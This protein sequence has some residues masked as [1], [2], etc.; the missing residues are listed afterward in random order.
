MRG[1]GIIILGFVFCLLLQN[2]S[3]QDLSNLK[4]KKIAVQQEWLLIDSL[5]IVNGSVVIK[6]PQTDSIIP[7]SQYQIDF[8]NG[9]LKWLSPPNIDSVQITYRHFDFKWDKVYY[10]KKMPEKEKPQDFML[11]PFAY[12]PEEKSNRLI[13]FG[14]LDYNGTY[15]RG[16]SFG[17]NQDVVLNSNFNMQLSGYITEDI[18]VIAALTDNSI[19]VQPDGNT[20]Q[21]QEFDKVFIQIKKDPHILTVGDYEIKNPEGHFLRFFRNLQG[22]SY[23]SKTTVD[24]KGGEFWTRN[25]IAVARGQFNRMQLNVS[26]GNQGPYRL[27]GPNGET[28]III[29]AGTERVYIDGKLLERGAENDYV[30]DYNLGEISFT[31]NVLITRNKRVIVE[32]EYSDRNY[33]RSLISSN[34]SYEREKAKGF[35]NFYSLQDNKNQPVQ[36]D[37]TDEQK[38]F[39]EGIGNSQDGALFTGYRTIEE[40]DPDRIL[41]ELKD[42]TV[43][44]IIYDTVFAYS[45]NPE[46]AIYSVSYSYVGPGNGNYVPAISSANGRVFQWIAPVNGIPQGTYAPIIS[47]V[48][49]KRQQLL[50]GGVELT[51]TKN[52]IIRIEGAMSNNDGNTFSEKDDGGNI[53]VGAAIKYDRTTPLD[54]AK[55][56]NLYTTANYEFINRNFKPIE[57]YRDVEFTRDWNFQ[58]KLTTSDEHLAKAGIKLE[59]KD[60][61]NAAYYYSTYRVG[62]EYQG[63]ISEVDGLF[64]KKGYFLDFNM[65]HLSSD[66]EFEKSKFTRATLHAYKAFEKLKGWKIGGI[67]FPER[68]ITQDADSDSLLNKSF[69]FNEW[70]VYVE[71]ADSAT[72]R[73][74]FE[75]IRRQEFFPE[76]NE[77]NHTNTSNTYAI[78]GKWLSLKHHKLIW[79]LKYRQFYNTDSLQNTDKPE[80]YYLGRVEYNLNILRG[81]IT[82]NI[83]YELGSGQEQRVEY[84]YIEVPLGQGTYIWDEQTDYNDNG[85][86]ELNEFE[87]ATEANQTRAN[88]IRVATP[89]TE[90]DPVDITQYNQVL[91]INPR[92][93]LSNKKGILGFIARFNTITSLQVNRKVFRGADVSVFNPFVFNTQDESL[94]AISSAIRQSIFFNRTNTKY[95]LEYTFKDNK[96]KNNLVNGF[97]TRTISEHSGRIRWNVISSLNT[98]LNAKMGNRSNESELFSERNYD[99]EFY[100]IN[101]EVNFIYRNKFRIS[102][103]YTYNDQRNVMGGT[104]EKSLE[105]KLSF[106]GRYNVVSKST[107]NVQFSY[108][109]VNYTGAESSAL[110]FAF[111]QG[112][113]DGDNYIWSA[114]FD[115]NIGKNVLLGLGYEGRKTGDADMIHT[116]RA[117]LR[118]IF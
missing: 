25:S 98:V 29:L 39:L 65:R 5:S 9:N 93:L 45:T 69:L 19:P 91:N 99:I 35:L 3:A 70:S 62:D 111:L 20:Q 79:N 50:T 2:G 60:W 88:H 34:H 21:L 33:F 59:H 102:L 38:K 95:S 37:I 44:N 61:G 7:S 56:F 118:A 117:Q 36:A 67:F 51:P 72:N 89:T 85:I 80:Q 83:L 109:A 4:S 97:E 106:E 48:T 96:S 100:E 66:G 63:N 6:Y 15:A 104:G 54:S 87:L 82:T 27:T 76:E 16:L 58:N 105:H 1:W 49:P 73:A 26:E 42:T 17:S 28:F 24:K 64:N 86:K 108:S 112:L 10:K 13:D 14:T 18:E 8:I 57:R 116:G 53:G 47:L 103:L 84:T 107:V 46:R 30:M 113:Q 90:Y 114:T 22:G 92:A 55:K 40:F 81:M 74:K 23:E 78:T 77:L 41:Y 71:N 101:P 11:N 31:P 75:Y 115:R 110:E 12:R 94:L 43:N 32:F 68:N 52:D